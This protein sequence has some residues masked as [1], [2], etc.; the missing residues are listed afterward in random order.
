MRVSPE[1]SR[2]GG[3]CRFEYSS[4]RV[5]LLGRNKGGKTEQRRRPGKKAALGV[6]KKGKGQRRH[7]RGGRGWRLAG[8]ELLLGGGGPAVEIWTEQ[9]TGAREGEDEESDACEPAVEQSSCEGKNEK[10][11]CGV[12]PPPLHAISCLTVRFFPPFQ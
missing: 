7:R 6:R 1:V 8:D 11:P 12:T 3:G 9:R 5:A 4:P 10:L 2:G